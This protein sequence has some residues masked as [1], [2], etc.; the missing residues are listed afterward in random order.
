MERS[1][2]AVRC[3]ALLSRIW[4]F[5]SAHIIGLGA[6][7]E[8]DVGGTTVAA[9]LLRLPLARQNVKVRFAGFVLAA[10]VLGKVFESSYDFA[11]LVAVEIRP[12]VEMNRRVYGPLLRVRS[13]N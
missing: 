8:V 7:L 12:L 5:R 11:K 1:G 13:C 4:G 10:E 3:S 6:R 9:H 2:I